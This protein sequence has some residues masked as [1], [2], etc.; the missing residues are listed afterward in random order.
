MPQDAE[1]RA[2]VGRWPANLIHDGSE[3]VLAAF[4]P[5]PGQIADAKTDGSGKFG[6]VYSPMKYSNGRDGEPSADSA[7]VGA[8]GYLC[9][10]ITPS[11]GTIL[12]PFMGSG[13]TGRGAVLE[14]FGF[15]GCELNPEYLELAK[16]RIAAAAAKGPGT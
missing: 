4:P 16:A 6:N 9:R 3:E 1:G 15:I 2:A 7:N 14:G 12:D 8:V 13:S 11:G 10:L 5:A